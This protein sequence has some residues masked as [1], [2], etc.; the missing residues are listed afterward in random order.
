[1]V[2][3]K[4]SEYRY[5]SLVGFDGYII[6]RK[7]DKGKWRFLFGVDSFRE[8][9]EYIKDPLS[10]EAKHK[11]NKIGWWCII[12]F[13]VISLILIYFGVIEW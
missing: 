12:A 1:V 13:M 11:S 7:V 10:I 4:V 9:E 5:K 2:F 3:V 6:E 8:A